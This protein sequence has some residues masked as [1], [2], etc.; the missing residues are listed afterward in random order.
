MKT[1]YALLGV[2]IVAIAAAQPL[3]AA[4]AQS[5]L[6]VGATVSATAKLVMGSSTITFADADPDDVTSIAADEN[7]ITVTAKGKTSLGS[8]ISLT[9]LASSDLLGGG[10]SIGISNITWTATGTGFQSGT[11]NKAAAQTVASWSN[12]GNRDGS[13]SFALVNSWA[14]ATG[15]YSATATFTLSAP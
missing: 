3:G 4:T 2:A 5:S 6:S 11:M 9:V 8:N 10:T 1:R 13:L 15:S 12:S 7:P 14:Y